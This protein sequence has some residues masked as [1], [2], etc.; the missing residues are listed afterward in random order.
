M[1][2][3]KIY[4]TPS[5]PWCARTK[6]F[7]KSHEIPFTNIDVSMNQRAAQEMIKKSGQMAVP[8][9]EVGKEVIL[10]YDE[11]RLKEVLKIK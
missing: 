8:V 1:P 6:E 3:V 5:C 7:L 11:D 9:I 4:S 2:K 10:G